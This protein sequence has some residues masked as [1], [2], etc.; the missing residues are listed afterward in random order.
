[1][2][3]NDKHNEANGETNQDGAND[4]YSWNMGAEGPTDDPSINRAREVQQRNLL[5]TLFFSQ[6]VPM[7]CGGDEIGRTQHGNNNPYCQDNEISWYN[8][9]LGAR[10]HRLLEFTRQLIALRMA[11]PNFRRR[12]FFQDREVQHSSVK[13]I[14]WYGTNGE[15]MT[16]QQW[17]EAWM[18]SIALLY[19]GSTLGE[20]DEMG[21]PIT[22]NSFL[23][24]LN[25][26]HDRVGYTLPPSPCGRGW[27]LIM[28]THDLEQ[29]F[30]SE[31]TTGHLEVQGRA[32]ALLMENGKSEE[33]PG[34]VITEAAIEIHGTTDPAKEQTTARTESPVEGSE[35]GASG[36]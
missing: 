35:S 2:S 10:Q 20:V 11:H 15:E 17:G 16:E 12:K 1:M 4:N 21:Q 9:D 22:D 18:R 29:P 19:N 6:G 24:L 8:W 36:T 26:H 27:T 28:E 31:D 23:I 32:V 3:Y 5:A 7:L 14:A 25:S 13:D 30:K 33:E 34:R